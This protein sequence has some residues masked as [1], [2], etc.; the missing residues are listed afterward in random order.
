MRAP[1]R[2]TRVRIE[3]FVMIKKNVE[4]LARG[5]L[6]MVATKARLIG[7][8]QNVCTE[9][10]SI[11]KSVWPDGCTISSVRSQTSAHECCLI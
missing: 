10:N 7:V 9:P 6:S 11:E 1:N 3:K 2:G 8:F 4:Q 5:D